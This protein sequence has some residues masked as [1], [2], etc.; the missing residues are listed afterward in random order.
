MSESIGYRE[1]ERIKKKAAR[2]RMRFAEMPPEERKLVAEALKD[3]GL[4]APAVKPRRDARNRITVYGNAADGV[5]R[6]PIELGSICREVIRDGMATPSCGWRLIKIAEVFEPTWS[7]A[8]PGR[9][10]YHLT[11]QLISR[12]TE[13]HNSYAVVQRNER[14]QWQALAGERFEIF[15]PGAAPRS[16]KLIDLLRE[17][18]VEPAAKIDKPNKNGV[19]EDCERIAWEKLPKK[20]SV[21][22]RVAHCKDG[23]R[24]RESVE[25]GY[26]GH[27]SLP[28]K[29][30]RPWPTRSACLAALAERV[31]ERARGQAVT[32]NDGPTARAR[33]GQLEKIAREKQTEYADADEVSSNA[34]GVEPGR[35]LPV[36]NLEDVEGQEA[37]FMERVN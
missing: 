13:S 2:W 29:T 28:S 22:L 8:I 37:L 15:R 26:N 17:D 5:E 3:V 4:E 10:M 36:A 19:F 33:W 16:D 34:A 12:P 32:D 25:V 9:P 23:Y 35:L 31:A 1:R 7:P 18:H 6:P 24:G 20:C 14:G 27:G 30:D 11:L 21:E